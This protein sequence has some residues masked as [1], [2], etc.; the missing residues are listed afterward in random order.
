VAPDDFF[1]D[2]WDEP[3]RTQETAPAQ[4]PAEK[5]PPASEPGA[6]ERAHSRR[7]KA[8]TGVPRPSSMPNLEVGRLAA[9]AVGIV[10]LLMVLLL[11]A[12]SCGGSSTSSKNQD[13]ATAV[14]QALKTNDQAA[15]QMRTLLRPTKPLKAKAAAN[16]AQSAV[17]LEQKALSQAQAIK[18]TKQAEPYNTALISAL[19]Y[20][21][22]GLECFANALPTAYKAKPADGGKALALCNQRLLASDV[23]YSDSYEMPLNKALADASVDARVPDS[24]F[25]APEDVST[26]TPA[27]MTASLQRLKP[28][29]AA[30]GLHGLSLGTVIAQSGSKNVTL[31]VGQVNAVTAASD[32]KFLVSA[33]NGGNF[34][35]VDVPV[36]VTLGTGQNAVSESGKIPQIQPNQTETVTITGFDTSA[37]QFDQ[38]MKLA[39]KVH[40]VVG[41][42]T[43]S[44]NNATYQI[45]FSLG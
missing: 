37:L 38:P 40:P 26:V 31:Q 28:G 36:T 33:T 3:S 7:P 16:V 17:T 20:R 25:L 19:S 13:Y 45:A 22:N 30:H 27:G 10:I 5:P 39:V 4:P 11:L 14:T 2:Q 1:D 41:E 35:E 34:T 18:P 29:T 9:L 43:T 23:V 8:K 32:L 6:S 15:D 21:V 12:R 42:H 44:N 24:V